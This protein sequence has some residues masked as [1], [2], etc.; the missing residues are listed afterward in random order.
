MEINAALRKEIEIDISQCEEYGEAKGSESLYGVLMAKYSVVD[1]QFGKG[2][3][4]NGKAAAPGNEFDFR[5]ELKAI[6]AKLR[7]WLLTTPSSTDISPNTKSNPLKEKVCSFIQRGEEILVKERHTPERGI[8]MPSYVSGPLLDAWMGEIII[9][10]ERYLKK[11]PLHDSIYTTYLRYKEQFSCCGD[12]L[13][14]LRALAT[15]DEFF[16]INQHPAS[17]K[18]ASVI[19]N[20]ADMLTDDISRCQEFIARPT[21]EKIGQNLYTEITSRYDSAIKGFGN[22]LYQYYAE[23]HFYDPEISGD[24]L[25]HNLNV[26][27]NKMVSFKAQKYGVSNESRKMATHMSNKVFIVHGHDEAAKQT[28]ARTL[29]HGGFEPII[30]HEQASSGRTIIEKIENYTDASFAVVLYTECDL[31]RAKEKRCEDEHYRARQNVV[32]EHGY[33]IGR[34]SRERVC[35][36]VK[37]NV[38]TPGDISGVVYISMDDAG[39]WKMELAKEMQNVGITIDMNS[40]CK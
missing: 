4:T 11:H 24:S 1:S 23:Q 36:L 33:L 14:H 40:F 16:E 7:M 21:D 37:G 20:M 19:P 35:A 28:M 30:L 27:L 6:A 2:L 25:T 38:E 34:L 31:G 10:N 39:A 12:M 8:V 29:E 22:G 9:F 26:L 32:F 18:T 3:S 5:Q 17:I 13:G 15:D